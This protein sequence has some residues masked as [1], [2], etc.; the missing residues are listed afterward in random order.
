MSDTFT[1]SNLLLFLGAS[2]DSVEENPINI[3][4][5]VL[6]PQNGEKT[7]RL[8]NGSELKLKKRL[9]TPPSPT[10]HES[11]M[12]MDHLYEKIEKSKKLKQNLAWLH[13]HNNDQNPKLPQQ[14][15]AMF[16][17]KYRP[18]SYLTLCPAGNERQY[19]TIMLW[20]H[21]SRSRSNPKK[22]LLVHGPPGIGKTSA[23]HVLARHSGYAIHE[24]NAASSMDLLADDRASLLSSLRLRI[25][26]ALTTNSVTSNGKPSCLLIDEVDCMANAADVVRVLGEFVEGKG[27]NKIDI[28]RPIVCI[29]NDLYPTST[30]F[31]PSPMDKLRPMCEFVAFRRPGASRSASG[32]TKINAAAQKAVKELLLDICSK[33]RLSLDSTDI[34]EI[35]DTCEGDIRACINH[36]QFSRRQKSRNQARKDKAM[37]W[38]MMVDRIFTRNPL[39]SKDED[40]HDVCDILFSSEGRNSSSGSLDKVIRGCFNR[41]LDVVHMLD[42]SAVRPAEI[43]DWLFYYDSMTSLQ[44]D[45]SV[46]ATLPTVKFW[47]LFSDLNSHRRLGD[48]SLLPNARA[49]EFEYNE[50]HRQNAALVKRF[51]DILP[52]DLKLSCCGCSSNHEVFA[53]VLLPHL[54]ALLSPEIGSSR[55]KLSLASH[56]KFMVEKLAAIV[57]A[58]GLRL[59]T[60]R[61]LDTN[62][63][64]LSF[65]PSWDSVTVYDSDLAPTSC[66]ARTKRTNARR[67]W[68]FPLI[69]AEFEFAKA[70]L[71]RSLDIPIV[72]SA[73]ASTHKKAKMLSSVDFFRNQYD[74]ISKKLEEP[75]ISNSHEKTRVWVKH[76]EGFSNAVRKNIGW[77]DLWA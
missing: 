35:F 5:S 67:A 34:A 28:N 24:L 42:D 72:E 51:S 27:K 71:K 75:A 76:N 53:C 46:Y 39:K 13:D 12:D 59:E 36:L 43:S 3:E 7:V 69:Q 55:V 14:T 30:R 26:N 64:L 8:F 4:D 61:D 17:E 57:K 16:T 74:H 47:S 6:F 31:G 62:V 20:L 41:Y 65:G 18:R 63:T 33:E 38:F 44:L 25:R 50:L 23:V 45:S 66:A 32:S 77:A 9:K 48:N 49:M 40:F 73:A 29:A 54:D 60:Q 58:L 21:N 1:F 11:F 22:I 52:L 2:N 68:L 15:S 19:R 10:K 37:S 56:E 70:P